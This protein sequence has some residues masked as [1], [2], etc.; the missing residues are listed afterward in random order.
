M[1]PNEDMALK[2]IVAA[3]YLPNEAEFCY[4]LESVGFNKISFCDVTD[5]WTDFVQKR[6]DANQYCKPNTKLETFYRTVKDLF[7]SGC[8]RGVIIKATK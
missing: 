8:L 5:Q 3:P 1:T 6:S 2:E 4:Q 7:V